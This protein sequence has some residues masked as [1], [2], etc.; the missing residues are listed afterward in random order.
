MEKV[1]MIGFIP[2]QR[3]FP[4]QALAVALL[5]AVPAMGIAQQ[6]PADLNAGDV[7]APVISAPSAPMRLIPSVDAPMPDDGFVGVNNFAATDLPPPA[8][9]ALPP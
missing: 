4:T 3:R 9:D 8:L 1:N 2:M 7:N 5:L 6:A